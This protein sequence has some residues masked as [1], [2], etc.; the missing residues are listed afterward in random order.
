MQQKILVFCFFLLINDINVSSL[1]FS[2]KCMNVQNTIKKSAKDY[3]IIDNVS[4]IH[5]K[6]K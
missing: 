2:L 3:K 6:T 5:D 1:D 4:F